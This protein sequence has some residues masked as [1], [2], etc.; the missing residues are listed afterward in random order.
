MKTIIASL[1]L[2]ICFNVFS[3][4][5][6][7]KERIR[8][9]AYSPNMDLNEREQCRV[10]DSIRSILFKDTPQSEINLGLH[11]FGEQHRTG[12]HLIII[13]IIATTIG[14]LLISDSYKYLNTSNS[15]PPGVVFS[16]AGGG[17]TTAGLIVN[18]NSFRYL[19]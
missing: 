19:R 12:N 11:K 10:N 8:L 14:G 16:V 1:L 2:L 4:T 15:F 3:Q 6:I 9:T 18:L 13:G 7:T 5:T 17:L